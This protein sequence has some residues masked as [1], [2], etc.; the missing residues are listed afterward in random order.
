MRRQPDPKGER[1]VLA[2]AA[3]LPCETESEA[4]ARHAILQAATGACDF[5]G[6]MS[7]GTNAQVQAFLRHAPEQGAEHGSEKVQAISGKA[8]HS[9]MVLE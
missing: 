6:H 4:S 2:T 1:C 8:F 7:P 5:E 9:D 3:I